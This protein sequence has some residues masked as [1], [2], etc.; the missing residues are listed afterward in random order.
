M[1]VYVLGAFKLD[2][3]QPVK[4]ILFQKIS[5]FQIFILGRPIPYY[6]RPSGEARRYISSEAKLF[7]CNEWFYF[8]LLKTL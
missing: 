7:T 3:L 1:G 2:P 6:P 5:T 4:L 8:Q